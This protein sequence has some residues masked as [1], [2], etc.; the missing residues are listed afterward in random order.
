MENFLAQKRGEKAL[1][2]AQLAARVGASE[3]DVARWEAGELPDSRCLLPLAE[4]LGVAVEDILRAAG[5]EEASGNAGAAENGAASGGGTASGGDLASGGD[6]ASGGDPASEGDTASGGDTAA[7]NGAGNA[8]AGNGA[9]SPS[10]LRAE[11]APAW[12]TSRRPPAEERAEH[13]GEDALPEGWRQEPPIKEKLSTPVDGFTR[14]ERVFGY[15]V[16]LLVLAAAVFVFVQR[17]AVGVELD[18]D[19]YARFLD[20]DVDGWTDVT[21]TVTSSADIEDF[22]TVLEV[23]FYSGAQWDDKVRRT[24]TLSEDFLAAGGSV[25]GS[26]SMSEGGMYRFYTFRVISVGGKIV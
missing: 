16:C 2:R 20:I 15:I 19:N 21:I 24:L 12:L 23:E 9:F 8:A 4:A 3:A 6:T 10:D 25:S 17:F 14:A 7:G 11:G 13:A 26:V 5:G 1:T 22:S 18:Q